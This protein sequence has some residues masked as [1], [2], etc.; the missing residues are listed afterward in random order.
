MRGRREAPNERGKHREEKNGSGCVMR[1]NFHRQQDE[2]WQA[3]K[4]EMLAADL[5]SACFP[6]VKSIVVT[7]NYVHGAGS[8][9]RRTLNFFPGN[10]AFFKISPLGQEREGGGIDLTYLIHR[11]VRS[12]E[13]VGTG[14][15]TRRLEDP[16]TVH[17]SRG[18]EVDYRVAITYA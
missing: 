4:R 1:S 12:R 9:V 15:F 16:G 13:R 10:P 18:Q 17:E 3:R 5:V 7:M 11:M 14:N 2:E 8:P 6:D